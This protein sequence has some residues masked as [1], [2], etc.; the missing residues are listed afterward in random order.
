MNTFLDVQVQ[1]LGENQRTGHFPIKVINS[2]CSVI[3]WESE[4]SQTLR[5][6]L[7]GNGNDGNSNQFIKK[8]G[9]FIENHGKIM[10]NSRISGPPLEHD[11]HDMTF[12]PPMPHVPP[13]LFLCW[14]QT[15]AV[16]SQVIRMPRKS[17]RESKSWRS[18][19]EI[20]EYQR[21]IWFIWCW[22]M[23][24]FYVCIYT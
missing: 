8:R 6:R 20:M 7:Y 1:S 12:W 16:S 18:R 9:K 15:A 14:T 4:T 17:R 2:C 10:E 21:Y 23:L 24:D 19:S 11:Q 5:F 22:Y 13:P 3:L